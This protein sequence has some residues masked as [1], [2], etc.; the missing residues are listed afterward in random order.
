MVIASAGGWWLAA[1][2]AAAQAFSA[3]TINSQSNLFGA[4]RSGAAPDPGGNGGGI[5]PP[6]FSLTPGSG[7][8]LTFTSVTGSVSYNNDVGD[9]NRGQ[10]N[11]PDGGFV[12]YPPANT[13]GFN[14][15]INS[16]DG[17][18]G[19]QLIETV[20]ANRRVMFLAGVF[21]DN[22]VPAGTAPARLDFSSTAL[23]TGFSSLSP[24]LNQT[25]F[26]G[27]GLTATGSGLQQQFS[28]PDTAT[29]L[30]LGFIDGADF[31]GDPTFYSNNDGSFVATFSAVPEPATL[32]I[33]VASLPLMVLAVRRLRRPRRA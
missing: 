12:N 28:V 5:L 4:G 17:V 13:D 31:Q 16:Y 19:L 24:L 20:S 10:F 14:T 15:N 25:F 3:Q 29:R 11:G 2:P 1:A 26:I 22:S 33:G 21:L 27:D 8:V 23:G 6:V 18:S 30:F 9:P 32:A 7:R